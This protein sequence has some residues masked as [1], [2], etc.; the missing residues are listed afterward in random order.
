[1]KDKTPEDFKQLL[2]LLNTSIP[3]LL[4]FEKWLVKEYKE[5]IASLIW[6]FGWRDVTWIRVYKEYREAK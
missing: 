4:L 6:N 3:D 5:T 1:M 2:K